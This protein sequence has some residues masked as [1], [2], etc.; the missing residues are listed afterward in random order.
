MCVESK[1]VG[2]T[3]W[4]CCSIAA[5]ELATVR[6]VEFEFEQRI[7][8]FDALA[9]VHYGRIVLLRRRGGRPVDTPDALIA[10][11]AASNGA[12]LATRDTRDFEGLGP[13]L[14]D[15]WAGP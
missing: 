10:A 9:L 14:I 7:L 4:S 3:Q 13:G 2:R 1:P 15:P 6:V 12:K 5:L 11:I 8:P